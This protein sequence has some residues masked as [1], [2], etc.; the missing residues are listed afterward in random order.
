[1]EDTIGQRLKRARADLGLTQS[2]VAT[3]INVKQQSYASYETDAHKPSL[4]ILAELSKILDVTTD[5]L[6]GLALI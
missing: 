5:Y 6:L 1:M 2:Q 4:E 3:L